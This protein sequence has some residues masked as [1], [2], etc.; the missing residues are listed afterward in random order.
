MISLEVT[1][2]E[3]YSNNIKALQKQLPFAVSKALNETGK[4]L[5]KKVTQELLPADFILAGHQRP[6]RGAP[7][8]R[9]GTALGFNL[10]FARKSQG[11]NMQTVLGSRAEWLAL[12]ET[13]GTKRATG[14]RVAVPYGARKSKFDIVTRAR[15]PRR[16][17]S[18]KAFIITMKDGLDA[19]FERFGRA[20]G[21]IRLL[22]ILQPS[23]H[24]RPDLNFAKFTTAEAGKIIGAI[25]EREFQKALATAKPGK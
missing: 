7:W 24:I 8:W 12:H 13:G 19:I 22:Y 16:V 25:F 14:G 9:P 1:G 3:T 6:A 18:K 23:A 2:L 4:I 21:D 10:Q 11:E 20:R 15:R 5:Q 17:L